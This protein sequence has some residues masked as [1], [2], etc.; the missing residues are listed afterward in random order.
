MDEYETFVILWDSVKFYDSI[1]YDVLMRE[2]EANTMGAA[3]G[4]R[5]P[6]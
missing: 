6:P 5:L 4:K 3:V 1:R 2:L